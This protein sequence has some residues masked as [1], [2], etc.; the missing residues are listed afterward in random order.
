[1]SIQCNFKH[2]HKTF[3]GKIVNILLLGPI[4]NYES[5][6]K[7]TIRNTDIDIERYFTVWEIRM[8]DMNYR[9]VQP[10]YTIV[11]SSNDSHEISFKFIS[12]FSGKAD[13]RLYFL[14]VNSI[15]I[16]DSNGLK[17]RKLSTEDDA[18]Y[19]IPSRTPYFY[20]TMVIHNYN[21]AITAQFI[22]L[23]TLGA[24]AEIINL[25]DS[26]FSI[27]NVLKYVF[28]ELSTYNASSCNIIK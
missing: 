8:E 25:I 28:N 14:Q 9:H 21:E 11:D 3:L 15:S 26:N 5:T 16:E 4:R 18:R 23:A 2:K 6:I 20:D 10:D 24:C 27:F 12:P 1:M 7:F 22:I 19:N 17:R 13:V